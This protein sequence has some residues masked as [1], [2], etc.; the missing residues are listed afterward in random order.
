MATNVMA[1]TSVF[2]DGTTSNLNFGKPSAGRFEWDFGDAGSKYN[3]LVGYNAAHIYENA[4]NFT[5]TLRVINEAGKTSTTTQQVNVTADNRQTVYVASNGDDNNP[6]TLDR[7]I[8]S[9]RKASDLVV[10]ASNFKVL[11]R[12]GDT[13]DANVVMY[14]SGSN[15]TVGSYGQGNQPV[16]S[17]S[18]S[19]LTWSESQIF[20]TG[21]A[22]DGVTIRDLY[23]TGNRTDNSGNAGDHLI[24]V[25][26]LGKRLTLLNNNLG[27]IGTFLNANGNIS[28]T[29]L[30]ENKEEIVTGMQA[31]FAWL[32]GDNHVLLGN[33][34]VNSTREHVVRMTGVEKVLVFDND[35]ANI[36]RRDQGDSNDIM[37]SN[38]NI[39]RSTYVTVSG[40]KLFGRTMVGPIV[41]GGQVVE[42]W[43]RTRWT[44]IEG[45]QFSGKS[46][47]IYPGTEEAMVRNNMFFET[48]GASIN[49][50]GFD[51]VHN[52]GVVDVSIINNTGFN[53]N[54]LFGN[55]LV[56]NGPAQRL[57]L[58]NN[59]FI[60]ENYTT[61]AWGSAPVQV[62]QNDL[63][64]FTQITNNVWEL[65]TILDYAAGGINWVG[66]SSGPEG[67]RTPSV[68][69]NFAQVGTDYFADTRVDGNRAP[70]AGQTA[71]NAAATTGG[72][73]TDFR[74]NYRPASGWSA[75]AVQG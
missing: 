14:L 69:N 27:Y 63:S 20:S 21:F 73:F 45:N 36:D 34:V 13:F 46:L 56:V 58:I 64:S 61:G 50:D 38:I 8:R 33:K 22:S 15:I 48:G 41:A 1:G 60:G 19:R 9:F 55:F 12:R 66:T 30:Q 29:L 49:V 75:G 25:Q 52:R 28:G 42:P 74:G 11:F 68:W 32:Q 62:F 17:S 71:F 3:K 40:N 24:V 65:P 10:N 47:E 39:Q 51:P 4:G 2:V 6:G 70:L 31:Y 26:P 23:L 53:N 54:S 18:V 72:V 7:P 5:V 16:I 35:L 43:G 44:V 59:L 57:R 37:K 67:Y